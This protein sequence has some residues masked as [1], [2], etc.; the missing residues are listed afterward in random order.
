MFKTEMVI[1]RSKQKKY[2]R[3]LKVRL[4]GKRLYPIKHGK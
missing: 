2:E 4:F 1:F 3:D